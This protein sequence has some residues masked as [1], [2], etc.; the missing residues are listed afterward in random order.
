MSWFSLVH[1]ASFKNLFRRRGHPGPHTQEQLA[2]LRNSE[3]RTPFVAFDSDALDMTN[4]RLLH[5]EHT[6][7]HA[8]IILHIFY[9]FPNK[10]FLNKS[11]QH[12]AKCSSYILS[13]A[14]LA[15]T[16]SWDPKVFG[17]NENYVMFDP[18]LCQPPQ[19][20]LSRVF[21][22]IQ[23]PQQTVIEVMQFGS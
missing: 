14:L 15:T 22:C 12:N 4:V 18:A 17:T 6:T 5:H 1:K 20:S 3:T 8:L 2:A 11:N 13:G 23:Q 7:T 19:S 9:G 21:P 10:R 16:V